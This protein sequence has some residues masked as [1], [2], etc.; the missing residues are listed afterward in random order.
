MQDSRNGRDRPESSEDEVTDKINI[1]VSFRRRALDP[2]GEGVG[3]GFQKAPSAIVNELAIRV[4]QFTNLGNVRLKS[5][6][7]SSVDPNKRLE[8][9]IA[10]GVPSCLTNSPISQCEDWENRV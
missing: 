6:F 4:Q 8:C 9:R 1:P 10:S 5:Q 7:C 3:E 2:V